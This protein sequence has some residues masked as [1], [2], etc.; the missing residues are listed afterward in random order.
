MNTWKRLKVNEIHPEGWLLEQLKIQMKGLS[1][2]L[3]YI[4]ESVGSYSGWLGGTGDGWE[5][6]PYYL[7]GLLPLSYYLDDQ[8]HWDICQKFIDWTLN[9]QDESGNFGPLKTISDQWSRFQMLKVLIQYEEIT[10]D[11][12]VVPFVYGYL[13]F[14]EKRLTEIKIEGWSKAR[15][16][17]LLYV[18][19]WLYQKTKDKRVIEI[20]KNIDK[21]SLDW[22][23]YLEEFPFPKPTQ[24]YINWDKLKNINNGEIDRIV[25][26]HLTHI[27]NVTMGFKHPAMRAWIN[28]DEQYADIARKGIKDVI[29]HHGVVSGCINGD[30]HLAGNDPVQGSE[31]CSVVEYMFSLQSLMEVFGDY[32]YADILERLAY[33]ALPATITEDFMAHQYLQ[34]ANQVVADIEDRPWFNNTNDSNTYGLEPHF[35]CC[36][37]NMHQGWPKFVNSLWYTADNTLISSVFAPSVVSCKLGEKYVSVRLITDYPFKNKLIYKFTETPGDTFNLSIRVPKWCEKMN[38]VCAN[39]KIQRTDDHIVVRKAFV[40]GDEVTVDLAMEVRY[41]NWFHNSLA[42]ERGPLVYGLDIQEKWSV[43]KEVNG[44][45]DYCVYPESNWNYA[46][47]KDSNAVVREANVSEIPFSKEN[48]PISIQIKGKVLEDW[49]LD[50]GNTTSLPQSPVQC[51]GNEDTITLIPFGCTKLRVSEFPYYESKNK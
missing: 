2:K 14:I 40:P 12:R 21:H 45:K 33:N 4:W 16:P 23:D 13:N 19:K 15:V 43:L 6:V 42:V 31:L 35:G 26:Y 38:V 10:N 9:S 20:L 3:F 7:D 25:P 50:N 30:E 44:I 27:V 5:R 39:A 1:G 28:D 18:G 8:E 41:S 49:R 36:T 29:R 47:N 32:S 17:E 11:S 34:Q 24:Y 37:A 48:P 22:C 46:L 51:S